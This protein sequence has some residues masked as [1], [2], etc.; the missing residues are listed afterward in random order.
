MHVEGISE[1]DF[2]AG[3]ALVA[4]LR[5]RALRA[6]QRFGEDARRGG[7]AHAAR[8]GKNVGV[9]H[10]AGVDGVGERARDVLLARQRRQT[11]AAAISAR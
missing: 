11:F 10:A 1:A 2:A 6:V 8:A 9:R 3:V 4:G 5:R 7:F